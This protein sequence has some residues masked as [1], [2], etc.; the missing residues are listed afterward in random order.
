MLQSSA[1][2]FADNSTTFSQAASQLYAFD[3]GAQTVS[4]ATS[5]TSINGS[6]SK[7]GTG[8]LIL[9]TTSGFNTT[10]SPRCCA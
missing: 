3:T 7:Y 1:A 4:F 5:L 8:T 9:N 2:N 6:L 10:F